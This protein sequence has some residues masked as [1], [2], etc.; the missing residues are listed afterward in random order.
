MEVEG[1]QLPAQCEVDFIP[2][3]QDQPEAQAPAWQG[4]GFS[5]RPHP[6]LHLPTGYVPIAAG[7]RVNDDIVL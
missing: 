6:A 4:N 2:A 1:A 5:L 3:Q 7:A